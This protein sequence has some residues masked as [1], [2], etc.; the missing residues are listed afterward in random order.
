MAGSEKRATIQR[1]TAK[2][3]QATD[4][5]GAP[6]ACVYMAAVDHWLSIAPVSG[7]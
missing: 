5:V 6:V 7:G 1:P 4:R 3:F 2:V